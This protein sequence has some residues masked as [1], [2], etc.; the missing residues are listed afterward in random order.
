MVQLEPARTVV[1]D[2]LSAQDSIL[3][4][5]TIPHPVFPC[6]AL[7]L[8]SSI[9]AGLRWWRALTDAD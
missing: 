9:A 2:Q 1:L 5:L 3:T 7:P 8:L 4:K 6:S